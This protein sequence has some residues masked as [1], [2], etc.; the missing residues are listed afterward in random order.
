MSDAHT[1][2]DNVILKYRLTIWL[3][4]LVIALFLVWSYFASVDEI[5]RGP[6]KVVP[7]TQTQVIQS[8]EGGIL[9]DLLVREGDVIEKGDIVAQLSETQFKGAFGELEHQYTALQIRL[10]RLESELKRDRI[11]SVSEKLKS[12]APDVITSEEQLFQ[13]GWKEYHESYNALSKA[14]TLQNK[15]VTLLRGL[16]DKQLVSERELLQATRE[17]NEATGELQA[18]IN[19]YKVTKSE[20]YSSTLNELNSLRETLEIRKDQLKRTTLKAPVRSIVNKVLISTIGGV[21]AP[22]EEI[23]ELIPLDDELTIEAKI[24]PQDI[25]FIFPGMGAT[26]KLT[27]YD[28][29]IYG[30]L[31]GTVK[32]I[33]AD[34][35]EDET[36]R[37]AAPYYKVI[38]E[39]GQ[40][41]LKKSTEEIE[42]RPGMIAETELHVGQKTVLQYL[43]KPLF[44]TREAFRER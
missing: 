20:D 39:V 9:S 28:Y 42:I 7:T 12:L 24:A 37:D 3:V 6:G 2:D 38:I 10:A 15:E 33:S 26:I 40:S 34:T 1:L 5:V 19:D 16:F 43:L 30:N 29:T 11:F 27:A 22:G 18:F 17:A 21:I 14:V 41:V 35:F 31:K 32:H 23:I 36:H 44:K 25:A 8:L 4:A 13:A